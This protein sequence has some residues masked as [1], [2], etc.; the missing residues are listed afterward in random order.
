MLLGY[1]DPA[2]VTGPVVTDPARSPEGVRSERYEDV[3]DVSAGT[4]GAEAPP[5]ELPPFETGGTDDDAADDDPE[6]TWI[7]TMTSATAAATPP[8]IVHKSV[9]RRIDPPS[10]PADVQAT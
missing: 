9:R 8:M 5:W 6:V 10:H 2:I 4:T 7:T 1:T 3:L